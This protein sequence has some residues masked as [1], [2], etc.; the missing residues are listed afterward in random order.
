MIQAAVEAGYGQPG[1]LSNLFVSWQK[2]G[3]IGPAVGKEGDRRGGAGLWHS[4][5]QAVWLNLLSQRSAGV[6][7]PTLANLPVGLWLLA[8]EGVGL[9]Q[10][11]RAFGFWSDPVNRRSRPPGS[12]SLTVRAIRARVD[13]L[14]DERAPMKARHDL[15]LA[16]LRIMESSKPLELPIQPLIDAV[17]EA[18]FPTRQYT[19]RQRQVAE[20]VARSVRLQLITMRELPTLT[21]QTP[22]V[23]A[24][25]EWGAEQLRRGLEGYVEELD[26]LQSMSDVGRL[27]KRPTL[28]EFLNSSCSKLAVI[29]GVGIALLEEKEGL[30]V[31]PGYEHPPKIR[32]T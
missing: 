17:L 5:Q 19:P 6:R 16:F 18:A 10:V 4:V 20:D 21:R 12:R 1:Q 27:F 32:L 23:E 2:A 3:L 8:F 25:W 7:L 11:Q 28:V 31:P 30:A 24:F 26:R 29:F 22:D 15:H 14:V 9:D 13:E